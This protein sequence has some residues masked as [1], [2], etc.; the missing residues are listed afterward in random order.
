[1]NIPLKVIYV[2]VSMPYGAGEEFFIPEV[3][4]MLKNGHDIMIVPRSFRRNFIHD[5]AKDLMAISLPKSLMAIEI[6]AVAFCEALRNPVRCFRII[7]TLFTG[8]NISVLLK[9]LI[10]FTKSLWLSRLAKNVG[11]DHIHA[12]WSSTTATMAMIAGGLS[13]IP[14][15]FTAHRVI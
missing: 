9:N 1:V 14:W 4:A 2:T 6:L 7:H 15:S 12:Q 5:D 3:K 10:V 8:A 13:G 11:A